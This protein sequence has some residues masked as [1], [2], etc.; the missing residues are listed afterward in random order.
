MAIDGQQPKHTVIHVPGFQSVSSS[1]QPAKTQLERLYLGTR[2]HEPLEY[3][4]EQRILLWLPGECLV[5][6]HLC[7]SETKR[8]FESTS[9]QLKRL[10]TFHFAPFHNFIIYRQIYTR[11]TCLWWLL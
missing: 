2:L 5:S 3:I 4:V 11:E 9:W 1:K 7:T 10:P 6:C 8:V